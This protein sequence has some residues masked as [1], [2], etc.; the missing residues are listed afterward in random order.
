MFILQQKNNYETTVSDK[1][2]EFDGEIQHRVVS[3]LQRRYMA[4]R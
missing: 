1:Y 4:R 2:Y 3:E